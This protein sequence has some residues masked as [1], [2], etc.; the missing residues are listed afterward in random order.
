MVVFGIS[1]ESFFFIVCSRFCIVQSLLLLCM[2]FV[3]LINYYLLSDAISK[4]TV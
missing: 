3:D 1:R 2:G 4:I